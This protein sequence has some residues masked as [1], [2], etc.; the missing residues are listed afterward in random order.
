MLHER[1]RGKAL[2]GAYFVSSLNVLFCHGLAL[3]M[4]A[5]YYEH[6]NGCSSRRTKQIVYGKTIL[7]RVFLL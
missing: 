6:T 1:Q 2:G 7:S 4:S 3:S 5:V